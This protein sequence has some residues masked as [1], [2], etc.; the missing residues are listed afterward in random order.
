MAKKSFDIKSTLK[1]NSTIELPKRIPLKKTEKDLTEVNEKI[2]IIHDEKPVAAI[3]Q[4]PAPVATIK[5]DP[6]V[7]PGPRTKNQDKPK[8]KPASK[9]SNT[10]IKNVRMT[11]DTPSDMH[12]KLKIKSIENSMSLRDY[13]LMLIEKDL[14][15]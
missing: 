11:I 2:A 6:V 7:D 3:A 15:R 12:I 14:Y 1:K 10:A 13:V 9:K 8:K 4:E 5:D